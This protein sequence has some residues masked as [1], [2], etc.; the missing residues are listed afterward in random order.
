M[1]PVE[2]IRPGFTIVLPRNGE[3]TVSRVDEYE[4]G[5]IVVRYF[6]HGEENWEGRNGIRG[7]RHYNRIVERSLRPHRK[8]EL[9]NAH[10]G[11]AIKSERLREQMARE[12]TIR[13]EQWLERVRS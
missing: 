2:E 7:V 6:Q 9:V 1:I 8:G 10:H 11:S 12:Q 13:D 5:A 3:R 4:D